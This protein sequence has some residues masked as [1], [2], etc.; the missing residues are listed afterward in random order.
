[1]KTTEQ[2]RADFQKHVV[3]ALNAQGIDLQIYLE[4]QVGPKDAVVLIEQMFAC[5]LTGYTR[6]F[7]DMGM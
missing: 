5:Y 4:M 2:V 7:K 3:D 1:M 6:A